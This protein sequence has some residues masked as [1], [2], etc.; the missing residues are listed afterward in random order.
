MRPGGQTI[1]S[2]MSMASLMAGAIA[3]FEIRLAMDGD[4]W[5]PL[6]RAAAWADRDCGRRR[7]RWRTSRHA[8][9]WTSR[10]LPSRIR[11]PIVTG[12]ILSGCGCA[13]S[14]PF[15]G[16]SLAPQARPVGSSA[17]RCASPHHRSAGWVMSRQRSAAHQRL[18]TAPGRS[19]RCQDSRRESVQIA[20]VEGSGAE[21]SAED[22]CAA[23]NRPSGGMALRGP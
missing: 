18:G 4:C 17:W 16:P 15:S 7:K 10:S 23:V 21:V 3:V 6:A 2:G 22:N 13:I 14:W 19:H 20:M 8:V 9:Q 12:L 11:S 1:S 5:P